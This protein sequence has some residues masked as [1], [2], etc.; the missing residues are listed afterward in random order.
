LARI[1]VIFNEVFLANVNIA[2]MATAFE[3]SKAA[4]AK[5]FRWEYEFVFGLSIFQFDIRED[6]EQYV[7]LQEALELLIAAGYFRA[8]IKGLSAF[9]KVYLN[10][11]S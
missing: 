9:D 11:T 5:V 1:S 7:K 8:R 2:G 6:E 10:L 4:N 3:L